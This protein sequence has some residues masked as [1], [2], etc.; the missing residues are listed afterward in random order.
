MIDRFE[1]KYAFLRNDYSCNVE[2]DGDVYP[3]ADHAFQA[4]KTKDLS[5]REKIKNSDLNEARKI[6]KKEIV[7]DLNWNQDRLKIMETIQENKFSSLPM[8]VRLL[9]TK[10]EELVQGGM[11]YDTYWGQD[12]SGFGENN[13]G[14]IIMKIREKLKNNGETCLSLIENLL[15]QNGLESIVFLDK[16]KNLWQSNASEKDVIL[17][18]LV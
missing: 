2:Y 15:K 18:Q 17:F 14:L 7:L 12:D 5:L 13:S 16:E 10:D 8:K 6:G 9:L 11:K 1:G 3:S 4:A